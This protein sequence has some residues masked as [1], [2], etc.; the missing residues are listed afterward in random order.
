M[1]LTRSLVL[2]VTVLTVGIRS[3]SAT[4]QETNSGSIKLFD[5][6]KELPANDPKACTFQ[7][8][9]LMFDA[10]EQ[11]IV[12]TVV[13]EGGNAGP[14]TYSETV[15]ADAEGNFLSSTI[16]LP[17]GSYLVTANDGEQEQSEAKYKVLTVECPPVEAPQPAP[18]EAA[19]AA[20]SAPRFTG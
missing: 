14:G 9:G 10:N 12:I 11:N 18:A 1:K 17:N 6:D 5:G 2:G 4:A 16:A 20:A 8:A 15:S 7:V 3:G 13:G 19:P